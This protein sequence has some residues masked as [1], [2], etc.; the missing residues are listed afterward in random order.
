MAWPFGLYSCGGGAARRTGRSST[1]G[2]KEGGSSLVRLTVRGVWRR[3]A[4]KD[5]EARGHCR[6][7]Q[8][9]S[10]GRVDSPAVRR[11]SPARHELRNGGPLVVLAGAVLGTCINGG[12][13]A[14]WVSACACVGV[15][16]IRTVQDM[17]ASGMMATGRGVA[18]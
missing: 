14:S 16:R 5:S 8:R 3:V 1:R 13:G 15:D 7:R 10:M 17:G 2:Q 18:A 11:L 9:S 12:V 4:E 6:W